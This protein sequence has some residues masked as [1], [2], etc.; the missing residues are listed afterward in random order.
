[1]RYI[2]LL[3]AFTSMLYFTSCQ[4]GSDQ[5]ATSSDTNPAAEGFN[6][7]ASDST[8]IHIADEV[9]QAMGGRHAWD[10][11]R[12]VTWNFFGV[13]S[14]LWDKQDGNVRIEVPKDSAIYL[15]NVQQDTGRVMING[16]PVTNAD[17]VKKYVDQ[18]KQIWV[19]DSYWLFMPFKLKD[20]GVTLTYAGTDTIQGGKQAEVLELKFA[21][22]G[23]TPDNKYEI[24]VDPS[25]SLVKQWAYYPKANMDTPQFVVPWKNYKEH[26]D[27]L[28]SGDRGERQISNI[29]VMKNVPETTF[30][31]MSFQM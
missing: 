28:L 11:T 19:N 10:N 2:F 20:S 6:K 24:Y 1:M 7:E 16:Q 14:L 8:A 31:S 26:G 9:M 25:D 23:F 30:T 21:N 29:E 5:Q 17:S 4:S 13:R 22:V 12:Y 18:G 27:I 3:I 15:I